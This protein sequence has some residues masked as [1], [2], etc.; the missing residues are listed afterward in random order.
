MN[1]VG[2]ARN[3]FCVCRTRAQ[4]HTEN[5]GI[6]RP[7]P[8]GTCLA[9]CVNVD[10]AHA[11]AAFQGFRYGPDALRQEEGRAW[12]N[13]R[14]RGKTRF[15]VIILLVSFEARVMVAIERCMTVSGT[16]KHYG[17]IIVEPTIVSRESNVVLVWRVLF[18][19]FDVVLLLWCWERER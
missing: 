5:S 18:F 10:V 13:K 4:L 6:G 2:F 16:T 15:C 12:G 19:L 11:L 9:P 3:F 1:G 14:G 7:A 8:L 17:I